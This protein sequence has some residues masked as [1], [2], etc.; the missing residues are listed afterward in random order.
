M[1]LEVK[2][3]GNIVL[4][5]SFPENSWHE[6]AE[7]DVVFGGKIYIIYNNSYRSGTGEREERTVVVEIE[8]NPE[9]NP[10][11]MCED[12]ANVLAGQLDDEILPEEAIAE[13]K[14]VIENYNQ[15]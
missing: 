11:V 13:I 7:I 1:A 12:I 3:I 4:Q 9:L 15:I 5:V 14:R 10:C 6:V 2:S 8:K